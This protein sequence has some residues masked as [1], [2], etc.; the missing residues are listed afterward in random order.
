MPDSGTSPPRRPP[1]LL[2]AG[3]RLFDGDWNAAGG[4]TCVEYAP[5][6]TLA[7]IRLRRQ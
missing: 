5:S 1:V 3:E 6:E 7:H 2:G 4:W